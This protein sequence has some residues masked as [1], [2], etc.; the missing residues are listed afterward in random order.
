MPERKNILRENPREDG[1]SFAHGRV[2]GTPFGL[3]ISNSIALG[4]KIFFGEFRKLEM[5]EERHGGSGV[6]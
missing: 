3:H 1:P 6:Q 5:T 4:D 2:T